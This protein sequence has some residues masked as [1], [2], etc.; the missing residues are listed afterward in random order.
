MV[1]VEGVFHVKRWA[2]ATH[3]CRIPHASMQEL[4]RQVG[5]FAT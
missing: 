5:D 1:S 2:P 3:P 4:I